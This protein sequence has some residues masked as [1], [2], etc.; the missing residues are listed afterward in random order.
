MKKKWFVV[1]S[2][3]VLAS[4]GIWYVINMNKEQDIVDDN[5]NQPVDQNNVI[6]NEYYYVY[7]HD[8]NCSFIPDLLN[9]DLDVDAK[10]EISIRTDDD[11]NVISDDKM[12]LVSENE[13][14][15]ENRQKI[16]EIV[17][18]ENYN[19]TINEIESRLNN[20]HVH[21]D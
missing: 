12:I 19:E 4:S 8:L 21:E 11:N 2:C 1:V 18:E 5:K 14:S 3:F 17:G 16:L 13:L 10:L 20:C 6:A 15:K 7:A 9:P